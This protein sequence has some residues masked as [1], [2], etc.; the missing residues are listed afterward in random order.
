MRVDFEDE[1]L[2]TLVET[3]LTWKENRLSS[4]IHCA[5]LIVIVD[6]SEQE[7]CGGTNAYDFVH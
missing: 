3:T 2:Q 5:L 7:N 6:G 4:P 1:F